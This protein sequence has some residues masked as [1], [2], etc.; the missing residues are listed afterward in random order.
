MIQITSFVEWTI[1]YL[2]YLLLVDLLFSNI[3]TA[4]FLSIFAKSYSIFIQLQ[5][6]PRILKQYSNMVISKY[7]MQIRSFME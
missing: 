5:F 2:K 7:M 1:K 6:K 4:I 3:L